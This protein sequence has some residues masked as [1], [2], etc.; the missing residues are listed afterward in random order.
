VVD[1]KA[2]VNAIVALLATGGSTNHT[3]HLVAI[4][5]AAGIVI[6]WNDFDELSKWCRCCAA[7]TRTAKPT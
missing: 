3:L 1:E 7:S 4:A 5:K 2:I 6:D